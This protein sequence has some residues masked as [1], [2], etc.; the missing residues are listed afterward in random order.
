MAKLR[1]VTFLPTIEGE[2]RGGRRVA[3]GRKDGDEML[4]FFM[5]LSLS[6]RIRLLLVLLALLLADLAIFTFVR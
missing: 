4:R 1:K 6:G 2:G 5:P 3:C